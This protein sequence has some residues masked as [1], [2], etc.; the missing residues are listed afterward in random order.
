M[1]Y[2]KQ[3]GLFH[4]GGERD[5]LGKPLSP[6]LGTLRNATELWSIFLYLWPLQFKLATG[7]SSIVSHLKRNGTCIAVC[8]KL[9]QNFMY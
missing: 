4:L 5:K 7:G 6:L 2:V 8:H 9:Y 1:P 3:K